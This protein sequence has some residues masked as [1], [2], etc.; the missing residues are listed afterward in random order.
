MPLWPLDSL[1]GGMF[2]ACTR[3]SDVVQFLLSFLLLGYEE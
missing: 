2:G 1:G 3:S